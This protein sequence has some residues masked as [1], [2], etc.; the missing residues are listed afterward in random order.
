MAID[1]KCMFW[2][3]KPN[4][5]R[6]VAKA[7]PMMLQRLVQ[8]YGAGHSGSICVSLNIIICNYIIYYKG[9]RMLLNCHYRT[10]IWDMPTELKWMIVKEWADFH[11]TCLIY[12]C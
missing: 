10:H 5:Y 9:A 6:F 2:M 12:K 1:G 7:C 3:G 4:R 11:S 8:Y